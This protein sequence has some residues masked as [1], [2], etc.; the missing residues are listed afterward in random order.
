MNLKRT[1]RHLALAG[2]AGVSVPLAAEAH[3]GNAVSVREMAEAADFVFV[4]SVQAINFRTAY[5]ST[6]PHTFVRFSI[7]RILKGRANGNTLTLRF[8]GGLK[9]DGVSIMENPVAPTFDVGERAVLFVKNNGTSLCPLVGCAEGRLRV[10]GGLVYDE[11]GRGLIPALDDEFFLAPPDVLEEIQAHQVGNFQIRY[12]SP[13]APDGDM[14]PGE[15]APPAQEHGALADRDLVETVIDRYVDEA[16]TPAEQAAFPLVVNL[17]PDTRFN[18]TQPRVVQN[19]ASPAATARPF[20]VRTARDQAE[21]DAL[22]R[23]GFSPIVG[24]DGR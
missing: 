24:G 19:A 23:N 3:D 5:R 7:E 1:L 16:F 11:Q 10:V 15:A 8:A 2:L 18:F 22:V 6:M 13:D 12:V 14:T 17:N 4:G 21:Y 20:M 9:S